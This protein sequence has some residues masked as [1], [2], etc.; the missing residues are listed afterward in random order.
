MSDYAAMVEAQRAFFQSGRTK[1]LAYRLDALQRLGDAVRAHELAIMEALRTDLNKS[2]FEAYATEV[3]VVLKEIR[4]VLR[5]LRKWARPR[6]VGAPLTHIG[7]A[8]YIHPEP[9]GVALIISPWNFPF[10]LALAPLIGA[11]AAGN[12]A[13]V[14]PSELTPHTSAVIGRIVREAFA[15]GHVDVAPGGVETSQA[16]LAKP[17]D[18]IF[19]TG[20]T[21]VGRKV[22]EAAARQLT[23]VTLELGGKS[24]CIVA[25]DA[26]LKLAAKRIVWG[27]FLNAGQTCIA[28]DYVYVHRSVHDQLVTHM[29]EA[30]EEMFG[31]QHVKDG[32]FTRIVNDRH[33][34]RLLALMQQGDIVHGGTSD[35]ALL[36]IE[37]TLITGITWEAAIMQ[38][39]IFG[40][41]LPIMPFDSLEDA[42]REIA[43]RPKPLALYVFT[44][45]TET[46]RRIIERVPF[47]GGCVN[48]TIFHFTS[49]ELPFGGVGASGMGA[50]HGR[51]SFDA[52][53]HN[54]S[55][56]KQT[57]LFDIPFRYPHVKHALKLLRRLLR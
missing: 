36:T 50:Y 29:K 49:P 11:I 21:E 42:S 23:P 18:Y 35:A 55:V 4:Y 41:L 13:V 52:F 34:R 53:S 7:S 45:D 54:K 2:E 43:G 31:A 14:K 19:F 6:K 28:P 37:P 48:D 47:G 38:E 16:L 30:I 24:P 33:F 5:R 46:E 20:G 27:K 17:F 10:Q 51:H 44:Q 8:S 40:P 15:P 39:E 12:C 22:M 25:A 57:T 1:A 32:L 56:L 9:Y 3:G 26:R